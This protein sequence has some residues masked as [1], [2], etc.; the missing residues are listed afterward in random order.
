M[1]KNNGAAQFFAVWLSMPKNWTE[2]AEEEKSLYELFFDIADFYD[3]EMEKNKDLIRKV[4][5]Y[6]DLENNLKEGS[7]SSVL[8]LED[9]Y[10]LKGRLKGLTG[11]T[12][13]ASGS[14]P[15]HGIMKTA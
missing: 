8:T 15:L 1:K 2:R 5:S 10:I 14:S 7:M 11:Y 4:L 3:G 9:G 6:Q 13:E 12:K